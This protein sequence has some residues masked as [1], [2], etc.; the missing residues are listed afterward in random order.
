MLAGFVE[1]R[2]HKQWTMG[3]RLCNGPSRV[4]SRPGESLQLLVV[5]I[6]RKRKRTTKLRRFVSLGQKTYAGF[7]L[8]LS[9]GWAGRDSTEGREEERGG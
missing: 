4:E 1:G 2:D 9:H 8:V 3:A 5:V 7:L 6:G